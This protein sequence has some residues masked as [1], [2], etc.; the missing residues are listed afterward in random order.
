[1][2][3]GFGNVYI[4]FPIGKFKAVWYPHA[5]DIM[6]KIPY[7][8]DIKDIN[9]EEEL[10]RGMGSDSIDDFR[11]TLKSKI[12]DV[13]DNCVTGPLY[14]IPPKTEIMINCISYYL[15][16]YRLID[17]IREKMDEI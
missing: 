13:I 4:L 16:S 11:D 10:K 3:K 5:E 15:V 6:D 17:D 7:W 8:A 1:M 14:N 12:Q 9:D 2:A